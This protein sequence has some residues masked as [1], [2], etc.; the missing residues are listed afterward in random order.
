MRSQIATN[1]SEL[2][3]R[4]GVAPAT[5]SRHVDSGVIPVGEIALGKRRYYSSVQVEHI[6][7]Y[8]EERKK[9]ETLGKFEYDD[10]TKA[11]GQPE[12]FQA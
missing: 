12:G 2:A 11:K 10:L 5:I 3:R 1:Q 8:F 4:C 6:I 7:R 9:G